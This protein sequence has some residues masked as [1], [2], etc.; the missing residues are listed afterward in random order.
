MAG[1]VE[2]VALMTVVSIVT[3]RAMYA[4]MFSYSRHFA[5]PFFRRGATSQN[6]IAPDALIL[7]GGKAVA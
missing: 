3:T 4:P 2:A 6:A 5:V 1:V 7:E